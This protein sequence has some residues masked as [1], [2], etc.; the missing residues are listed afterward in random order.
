MYALIVRAYICTYDIQCQITK[1]D[2]D[3]SN[4]RNAHALCTLG[5]NY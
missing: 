5:E 4:L 3:I 2:E 1:A